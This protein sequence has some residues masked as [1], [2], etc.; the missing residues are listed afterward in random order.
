MI[1][2][3]VLNLN[4]FS[5]SAAQLALGNWY[6]AD[7][8]P[9]NSIELDLFATAFNKMKNNILDYMSELESKSQLE[10]ELMEQKLKNAQMTQ[11]VKESQL[12]NLQSQMN[13]HFL[14]NLQ[15]CHV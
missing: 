1:K 6:I 11:L 13:P 2:D 10:I 9:Q 5:K 14:Y 8:E 7:I 4:D 15:N 3:I 12:S